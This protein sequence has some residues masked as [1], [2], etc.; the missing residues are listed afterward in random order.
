M[1]EGPHTL[2]S[3]VVSQNKD[4]ETAIAVEAVKTTEGPTT[5]V[6]EAETIIPSR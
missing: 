1:K 6:V 4:V 5:E 2:I 3:L